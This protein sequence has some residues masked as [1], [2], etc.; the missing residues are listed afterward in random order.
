[1]RAKGGEMCYV[2]SKERRGEGV[3]W[4]EIIRRPSNQIA[5][6]CLEQV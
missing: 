1:M 2:E 6:S 3:D 4:V 5:G